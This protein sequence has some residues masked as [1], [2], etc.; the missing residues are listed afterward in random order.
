MLA[1][2]LSLHQQSQQHSNLIFCFVIFRPA[3][4]IEYVHKVNVIGPLLVSQA[5]LPLI[6]KGHKKVVRTPS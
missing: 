4:D 1:H 3:S 2:D 5:M 6:K